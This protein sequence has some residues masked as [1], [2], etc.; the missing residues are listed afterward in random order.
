MTF[1]VLVQFDVPPNKRDEFLAAANANAASVD[2]EPGTLRFEVISDQFNRSRFYFDE[3]YES[4]AAF[5]THCQGDYLQRFIVTIAEYAFG[6]VILL[7]GI[8]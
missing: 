1:H 4:E 8:R 3:V 5:N 7:R 2:A 6:P